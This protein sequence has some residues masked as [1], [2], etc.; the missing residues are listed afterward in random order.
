MRMNI[1]DYLAG[2]LVV[3]GGINWGLVGAFEYNLVDEIFGVDS[4]G[5]DIVYVAVGIAAVYLVLAFL[6]KLLNA[7]STSA[8]RR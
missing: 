2:I 1:I 7:G 3:I 8:K 4:T 5:S 6:V